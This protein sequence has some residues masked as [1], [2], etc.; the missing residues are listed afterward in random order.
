MS[1]LALGAPARTR[2]S[3][4]LLKQISAGQTLKRVD[5]QRISFSRCGFPDMVQVYGHFF[6]RY[7]HRH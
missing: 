4:P 7:F 2:K 6:F 1:P 3:F 5:H